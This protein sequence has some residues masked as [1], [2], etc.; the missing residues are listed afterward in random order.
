MD[1]LKTIKA[2]LIGSASATVLMESCNT[3]NKQTVSVDVNKLLD[4]NDRIPEGKEVNKKLRADTFFTKEEMATIVILPDIIVPKDSIS[5]S[6]SYAKVAD[7]I[8]FIVKD[9]PQHQIPVIGGLRWLDLQS[10]N[11]FEKPFAAIIEQQRLQIIDEIAYP[12]KAK[13]TMQQGV[14]FFNLMRNFTLTGFYTSEIGVKD[15]GYA[16]N[17]PNQRN[18]VPAE[19]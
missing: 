19:C 5:G 10:L 14:T 1:R 8:E 18:G 4:E 17:K 3:K 6:A 11:R 12:E 9:M 16:S 15:I 7:L 2:L 13:G